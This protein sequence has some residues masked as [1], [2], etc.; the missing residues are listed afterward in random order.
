MNEYEKGYHAGYGQ[1]MKNALAE[2]G[3]GRG[4]VLAPAH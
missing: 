2:K 1:G 3:I 4:S